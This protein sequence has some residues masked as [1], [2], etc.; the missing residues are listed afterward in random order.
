[1]IRD[2]MASDA[3]AISGIYNHYIQSAAATFEEECLSAQVISRRIGEIQEAGFS[4]L[5]AEEE[6]E[7][8]GYA[9][10]SKWQERSAYRHTAEVTVYISHD[11]T[12]R[13]LG[14]L[15]YKELFSRL[16]ESAI[17]T[18]VAVIVLPN[19]AS[20]ALHEKFG[21]VQAAHF[22]QVGYKF[23]QWLDVGYWQVQ[24]NA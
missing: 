7:V 2:A 3:N 9:Y 5:V 24:L 21:M 8:S 16:R 22:K 1:M 4:W 12:S 13:G 20:V 15:L 10:S 6:G 11:T 19:D 14:T 17:H 23:D 18:V